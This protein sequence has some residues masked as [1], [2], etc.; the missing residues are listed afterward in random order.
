MQ[1]AVQ[2][3]DDQQPLAQQAEVHN[4]AAWRSVGR[5]YSGRC[6]TSPPSMSGMG[7]RGGRDH[8]SLDMPE[9]NRVTDVSM[10]PVTPVWIK[11]RLLLARRVTTDSEVYVQ[12]CVLDWP[13]IRDKLCA[14]VQ[15]L[16]PQAKLVPLIQHEPAV[17]PVCSPNCRYGWSRGRLST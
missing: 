10:G 15:D 6:P 5:A 13:G 16:L 12:G 2:T 11:E 1:L 3:N 7:K 14:D 9:S 4:N 8:P 17:R